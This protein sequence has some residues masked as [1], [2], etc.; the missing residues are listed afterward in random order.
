MGNPVKN[1][2]SVDVVFAVTLFAL[3]AVLSLMLVLI[4]VRS[5]SG[6]VERSAA[7]AQTRAQV[8]YLSNKVRSADQAG[9]VAVRQENGICVLSLAE[10]TDGEPYE[11][12]IYCHDG[13]LMEQLAAKGDSFEP[14]NGQEIAEAASFQ[15]SLSQ[16]GRLLIQV[17]SGGTVR[18]FEL[19]LRSR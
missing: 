16:S 12:L 13:K 1:A 9:G 17:G 14:G 8:L 18:S 15:A 19:A 6:A 3:F 11:T 5:Y 7:A 2:H 10:E 4:G